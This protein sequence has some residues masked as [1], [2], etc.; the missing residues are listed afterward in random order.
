MNQRADPPVTVAMIAG[1][2]SE[3]SQD[4]KLALPSSE[5]CPAPLSSL[6]DRLN[7]ATSLLCDFLFT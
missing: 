5:S 2:A 7:E 1:Q 3:I 4:A 6:I